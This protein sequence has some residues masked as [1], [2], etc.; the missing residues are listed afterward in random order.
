MPSK[1]VVQET[2]KEAMKWMISQRTS[3][4]FV[5]FSKILAFLSHHITQI[6][7]IQA[8]CHNTRPLL[9]RPNPLYEMAIM[10]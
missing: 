5:L 4:V 9:E 6:K 10:S 2:Q 8:G 1:F 7:A 3:E